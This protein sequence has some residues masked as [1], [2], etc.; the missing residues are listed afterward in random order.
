MEVPEAVVVADAVLVEAAV[1]LVM[2]DPIATAPPVS[3]ESL[4]WGIPPII[5][6]FLT[7][8]PPPSATLTARSLPAGVPKKANKSYKPKPKDGATPRF[9]KLGPTIP[10]LRSSFL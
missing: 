7:S 10:C 5:Y 4:L 1:E 2:I 3:S 8:F 9:V 6:H